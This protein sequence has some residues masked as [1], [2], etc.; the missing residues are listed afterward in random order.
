MLRRS[1]V[2]EDALGREI[3]RFL[4]EHLP[5]EIET[6]QILEILSAVLQEGLLERRQI[7]Q[8]WQRSLERGKGIYRIAFLRGRPLAL[9]DPL[10]QHPDFDVWCNQL[11]PL[12]EQG[13]AAAQL[14]LQVGSAAGQTFIAEA[15]RLLEQVANEES[16]YALLN[17]I[18]AFFSPLGV[19]TGEERDIGELMLRQEQ[20]M[21]SGDLHSV[22]ETVEVS[23]EQRDRVLAMMLL[24][25][26]REEVAFSAVLHSGSVGRSLRKRLN[27]EFDLIGS[28]LEV[29]Q[30]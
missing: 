27:A 5:F 22:A 9:P 6:S 28:Q 11:V 17:A 2:V 21:D 3:A 14:L 15:R 29:L 4:M 16:V 18:G 13:N 26:L 24:S 12:A 8:I 7:E 10:P 20:L 23:P 19:V 25:Q 30:Q 1:C